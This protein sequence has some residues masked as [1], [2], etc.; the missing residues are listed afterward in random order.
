[1]GIGRPVRWNREGVTHI[2]H[3]PTGSYHRAMK[4]QL[5]DMGFPP[6]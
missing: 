2:V 6:V 4:Q 3:E 5:G 1:V